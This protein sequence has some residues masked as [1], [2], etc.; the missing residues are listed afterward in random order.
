MIT[1][2]Y[3]IHPNWIL[4]NQNLEYH[5]I[6]ANQL[7]KLYKVDPRECIIHKLGRP[8]YDNLI[9]L[10]PQYDDKYLKHQDFDVDEYTKR[11]ISAHQRKGE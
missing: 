11:F 3:V 8:T 5:Y 9:P 7:I 6:T 1:K 4:S 2:K 10:Y